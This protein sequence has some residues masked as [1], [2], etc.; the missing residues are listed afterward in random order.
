V[1]F[2]TPDGKK[3]L[4]VVNGGQAPQAFNIRYRGALAVTSLNAGSVGTYAW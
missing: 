4:I 1:A 3:V 2:K